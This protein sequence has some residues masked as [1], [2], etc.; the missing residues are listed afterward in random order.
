M[1]STQPG[2]GTPAGGP[3][4]IGG[5]VY[6]MLWC[7]LRLTRY[8]VRRIDV[9][10]DAAIGTA[11]LVLEPREGGGDAREVRAARYTVT[12]LKARSGGGT[13]SLQ[14]IIKDVLPD[15][16]KAVKL[17]A[18]NPVYQFITDARRGEWADV[19][20]FFNSLHD[21]EPGKEPASGL[22]N[23]I[24]LKVGARQSKEP[25]TDAFWTKARYTERELFTKIVDELG[26]GRAR[27]G[28]AEFERTVWHLLGNFEFGSPISV[29]EAEKEIDLAL[30]ELAER[31]EDV[32]DQ[33]R[34]LLMRLAELARAGNTSIELTSFVHDQGLKAI[35]RSHVSVLQ[36]RAREIAL[37]RVRRCGFDKSQHVQES[38]TEGLVSAVHDSHIVALIGD[39]GSGKSWHSYALAEALSRRGALV[40]HVEAA[41]DAKTTLDHAFGVLWNTVKGQDGTL[42]Y[43]RAAKGLPGPPPSRVLIV[44]RVDDPDVARDLARTGVEELG[45][46]LVVAAGAHAAEPFRSPGTGRHQAIKVPA[47][48][49]S[50]LDDYLIAR[51]F[52]GSESIP[53]DVR[54]LLSQPMLARIFCDLAAGTGW[55]RQREGEA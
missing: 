33:R 6:Q 54:E 51:R 44:D 40:A 27:A 53:A 36:A 25:K 42:P 19:E 32:P 18:P 2:N 24:L 29:T 7:L 31:L 37:Q 47:L 30:S 4:T 46:R 41:S 45:I 28:R 3:S 9:D 13:W 12:Q 16:L 14:E 55:A 5:V 22:D 48:S 10:K 43:D 52:A 17:D 20:R 35:P 38:F 15:L 1:S 34:A 50:E 26:E 49:P 11:L 23:T 21:R 39:S 8:E